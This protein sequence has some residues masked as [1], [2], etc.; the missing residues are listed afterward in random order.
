MKFTHGIFFILFCAFISVS[1]ASGA[2]LEEM[3]REH[4][5]KN[6]MKLL[7]VE[8]PRKRALSLCLLRPRPVQLRHKVR[9]RN[10]LAEFLAARSPGKHY[11]KTGQQP[12]CQADRD[13][14]QQVRCPSGACL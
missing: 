9:I 8:Q 12:V 11:R 10:R 5:L 6:G 2:G 4:T 3:V 7:L 14:V 1:T 13:T